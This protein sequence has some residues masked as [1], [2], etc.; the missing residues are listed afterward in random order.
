MSCRLLD[1]RGSGDPESGHF[2]ALC[3]TYGTLS[4]ELTKEKGR[5]PDDAEYRSCVLRYAR[6]KQLTV[7]QRTSCATA[8]RFLESPLEFCR[9]ALSALGWSARHVGEVRRLAEQPAAPVLGSAGR[10][11]WNV[12]PPTLYAPNGTSSFSLANNSPKNALTASDSDNKAANG[13]RRLVPAG[14]VSRIR[15]FG[16][17]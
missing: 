7:F 3:I 12:F 8:P 14:S 6:P 1:F 17:S 13:G 11:Q 2:G 16:D 5:F 9:T 15:P 10:R 4:W